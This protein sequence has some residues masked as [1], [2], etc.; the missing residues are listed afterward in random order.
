VCPTRSR[1][2]DIGDTTDARAATLLLSAA[3]QLLAPIALRGAALEPFEQVLRGE[4]AA[5]HRRPSSDAP[6]WI[7]RAARTAA[8]AAPDSEFPSCSTRK[9]A[10]APSPACFSTIPPCLMTGESTRSLRVP[11][12]LEVARDDSCRANSPDAS[13]SANKMLAGRED[14]RA[15]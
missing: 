4:C 5:P 1:F 15:R 3:E 8:D 14:A 7:A 2:L 9:S 13:R 10:A 12:Q 6:S 11:D